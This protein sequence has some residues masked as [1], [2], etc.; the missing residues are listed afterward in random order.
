MYYPR[1]FN[2]VLSKGEA[3]STTEPVIKIDTIT[4]LL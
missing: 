1:A 3:V 4:L 2:H